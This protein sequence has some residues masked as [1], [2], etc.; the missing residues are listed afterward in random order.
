MSRFQVKPLSDNN[1]KNE[2]VIQGKSP[3]SNTI[4]SLSLAQISQLEITTST[5]I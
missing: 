3:K 4:S 5:A 2:S 1:D